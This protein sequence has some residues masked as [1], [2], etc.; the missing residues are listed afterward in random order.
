[1]KRGIVQFTDEVLQE[2]LGLKK[3]KGRIINARL[4]N[5]LMLIEFH[6]VAADESSPLPDVPE[7]GRSMVV[8]VE[9]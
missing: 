3:L 9:P 2:A 8:E 1:M 5:D 7:G 6:L 4:N